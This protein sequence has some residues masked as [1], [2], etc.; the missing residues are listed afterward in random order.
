MDNNSVVSEAKIL[1]SKKQAEVLLSTEKGFKFLR[2]AQVSYGMKVRVEYEQY[3]NTIILTATKGN[4]IRFNTDLMNFL[5][6][7]RLEDPVSVS[8][9]LP[10]SRRRLVEVLQCHLRLLDQP[11]GNVDH[12]FESLK[13]MECIDSKTGVKQSN[14]LRKELNIILFGRFGMRGGRRHLVGIRRNLT[15]LQN[16]TEKSVPPSIYEEVNRQFNYIF[17]SY[18]HDDY[19]GLIAECRKIGLI[20]DDKR[21][22]ANMPPQLYLDGKR[23]QSKIE[24]VHRSNDRGQRDKEIDFS[25]YDNEPSQ[26]Y[27][28][29]RE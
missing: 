3:N 22:T 11:C 8:H 10:K 7:A 23:L 12:I 21:R 16:S 13:N 2:D 25:R 27:T 20:P 26:R 4:Q 17:S 6:E 5:N 14:R 9:I 15:I 18:R 24:V 29:V 28:T 19:T 1:L